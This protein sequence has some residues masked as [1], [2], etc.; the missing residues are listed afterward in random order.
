MVKP[1]SKAQEFQPDSAKHGTG[2]GAG[3]NSRLLRQQDP[4]RAV[5]RVVDSVVEDLPFEVAM[6]ALVNVSQNKLELKAFHLRPRWLVALG[7]WIAGWRLARGEVS[8][9]E[10]KN[11]G[12]KAIWADAPYMIVHDL[13]ALFRP[14]ISERVC[15][16]LQWL[17]GMKTFV[18]MPFR[19]ENELIGNLYVGTKRKKVLLEDIESLQ[20]FGSVAAM[21]IQNLGLYENARTLYERMV[22]LTGVIGTIQ[23][24]L[25]LKAGLDRVIDAV[26][27]GLG[28]DAAM[29]ALV[30]EEAGKLEMKSYYLGPKLLV[31]LGQWIAGW[32]ASEGKVALGEERNIGVRVLKSGDPYEVTD[33]LY[34]LFG[35]MVSRWRCRIIQRGS[36]IKTL[37]TVPFRAEGKLIGN[38][39]VGSRHKIEPVEAEVL[40]MFGSQA[41]IAVRKAALY[42]LAEEKRLEA[43]QL[44]VMSFAA[45]K[46]VHGLN[47]RLGIILGGLEEDADA[48]DREAALQAYQDAVELVES[49]RD[50]YRA[51][52]EGPIDVNR[53]LE[54]ALADVRRKVSV[55]EHIKVIPRYGKDLPKIN[56]SEMLTE[57]FRIIIKNAIEAMNSTDMPGILR[58]VTRLD[59]TNKKPQI[60]VSIADTGKGIPLAVRQQMFRL[61]FT[62]K[63]GQKRGLGFGL[64]WVRLSLSWI[65]GSI[66]VESN[67]RKGTTFTI[68]LP[69]VRDRIT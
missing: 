51:V 59:R 19:V 6:L 12:A 10:L 24:T 26:V 34:Q 22:A 46:A 55:P 62:T 18:T 57:A 67:E 52:E 21:A 4:L 17:S 41:A 14:M 8:L 37:M 20:T 25:D 58:I 64:W 35:P 47:N 11:I 30:N 27:D 68:T 28:Y 1:K 38:L 31:L 43:T 39:Y 53:S 42:K 61:G 9:D 36:G 44:A 66:W 5:Q 32:K 16:L 7:Q 60:A 2:Q 33:D 40:H 3:Q 23:S 49:L 56:A 69:V 15:K 48:E 29:L 65:Q 13:H 45:T 63:K 50:P 54:R